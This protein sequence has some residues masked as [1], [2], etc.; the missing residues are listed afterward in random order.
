MTAPDPSTGPPAGWYPS[1]NDPSIVLYWGGSGW[2]GQTRAAPPIAGFGGTQLRDA[3]E[4]RRL[5]DLLA[6]GALSDAEFAAA[7]AQMPD[8]VGTAAA[9]PSQPSP[10]TVS[11][12]PAR[13]TG[14]TV[15][16]VLALLVAFFVAWIGWSWFQGFADLQEKGNQ[17]AGM[18]ALLGVGAFVV[19]GAFGIAGL[20]LLSRK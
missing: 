13:S 20:V 15:G 18:L 6:S 10:A 12:P 17:F 16:G 5:T 2:T 11:A 3:G 4:I 19:A 7:M 9:P 8:A 14:R 1:Q